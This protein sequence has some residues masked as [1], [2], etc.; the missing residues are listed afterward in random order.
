MDEIRKNS[1]NWRYRRFQ[2]PWWAV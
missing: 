2:E 1:L